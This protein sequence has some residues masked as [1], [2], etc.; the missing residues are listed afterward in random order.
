M[1]RSFDTASA[2]QERTLVTARGLSGVW[3]AL[4]SVITLVA[5]GIA[6]CLWIIGP[7]SINPRNI[8][9]LTADP[10]TH[11]LGWAFLRDTPTWFFPWTWTDRLGYPWGVSISFLDSIPLVA[12][13]LRPF[14]ALLGF[15]FQ[16]IGLYASLCIILQAAFGFMLAR[17]VG[18]SN[19]CAVLAGA[20]FML[21]PAFVWRFHGHYALASHWLI[22]AG[23]YFYLRVPA[24]ARSIAWLLPLWAVTAIG[25]AIN[26]YIG[27]MC[28]WVALAGCV[29]LRLLKHVGTLG[30]LAAGGVAVVLL[31]AS[32]AAFGFFVGGDASGYA[33]GGYRTYSLNLLS[34]LDPHVYGALLYGPLPIRPGQYEG[35]NYLG[36]GLIILLFSALIF[37]RYK[38]SEL[39]GPT[40]LPLLG[41]GI[42][43]TLLAASATIT[44]GPIVLANIPL[45]RV[46]ENA[47]QMLRASGRLFWPAYYLLI[48]V[49]LSGVFRSRKRLA[50]PILLVGLA[51]QIADIMPL[52]TSVRTVTHNQTEQQLT[53]PVWQTLGTLYPHLA[54]HPA[55]QC[56]QESGQET[57]GGA[58]GYAIFGMLASE[59]KMTLNS[60]Y[61]GRISQTDINRHCH[62]AIETLMENGLDK[63]TAYVFSGELL[64]KLKLAESKTHRCEDVNEY[65]LCT[66]NTDQ[67][68]VFE[69]SLYTIGTRI[70]FSSVGKAS[71]YLRSGWS[72]AEPWGRWTEGRSADV[73]IQPDAGTAA[74]L[75]IDAQA[76]VSAEG[77]PQVVQVM[78]NGRPLARLVFT[79]QDAI[80]SSRIPI[81]QGT[82]EDGGM[83][84]IRFENETP[85]SPA[86]VGLSA[87]PRELGIGVRK[88]RLV[89]SQ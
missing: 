76:F 69:T 52:V 30:M 82:T 7:H 78:V 16:F 68:G 39:L 49:A 53:N 2:P 28:L 34:P 19:P 83:I 5:V 70:D 25:G 77:P 87:D 12:I 10:A 80:Q 81:P 35:Y 42:V 37:R 20:F 27:V 47:A 63:N 43:S 79:A 36:L 89:G 85:R 58:Q 1:I 75:E 61:S 74:Y 4:V 6:A 41:L 3:P 13:A 86:E 51:I 71:K 45:P 17:R 44:L 59:Q 22:L 54:V 21:A 31:L 66:Y 48:L 60:Y 73:N 23:L 57:P 29:R 26:P 88:L 15:P 64:E 32:F 65:T 62:Q 9:W 84:T 40:A 72:V 46:L 11:Y 38:F 55:W 56:G 67:P 50:A 18:L 8:D 24:A 14:S 33:G